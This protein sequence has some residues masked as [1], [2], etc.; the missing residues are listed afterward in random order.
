M[1]HQL[2]HKPYSAA[3]AAIC[4]EKYQEHRELL[5]DYIDRLMWWNKKVNL[6]SRGVSRET[7]THHV[8]HSLTIGASNSFLKAKRVIDT[9]T[10]GGLPGIP[11]AILAPQKMVMLN[12]IVTKKIMACKHMAT[13]MGLKNIT[14]SSQS[15]QDVGISE[16][17]L[18]VSKHAFKVNDLI[19]LLNGKAWSGLILLKGKDE[20]EGEL[21]GL[22][23]P[24]KIRIFD[25]FAGFQHEFYKGKALVEIQKMEAE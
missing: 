15:I 21:D 17:S 12:D 5:S 8:Q 14:S 23:S 16:P 22:S 1:E 6:I 20:V 18:V 11:L 24:L 13:E 4:Q 7:I 3:D 2:I 9:G 10:G 25:L 19:G